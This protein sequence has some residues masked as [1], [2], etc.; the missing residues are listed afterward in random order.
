MKPVVHYGLIFEKVSRIG[1]KMYTLPG[2]FIGLRAI[3]C[4][5]QVDS[6]QP[7]FSLINAAEC[8]CF[9]FCLFLFPSDPWPKSY[10]MD[11]TNVNL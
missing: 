9:D 10:C 5:R 3:A 6:I 11:K 2:E 1:S 7:S 8:F 4:C